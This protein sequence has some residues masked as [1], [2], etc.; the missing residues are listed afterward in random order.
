MQLKKLKSGIRSGTQITLN[1]SSN[2]NDESCDDAN[3]SHKLLL[4]KGQV[5]KFGKAF[6]NDSSANIN[7]LHTFTHLKVKNVLIP[8]GLPAAASEK[9]AAI[10]KKIHGLRTTTSVFS[11]EDLKDIIKI[12]K[13]L[14]ESGFLI[15]RVSET[16]KNEAKAQ[17]G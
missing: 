17:K 9:D 2:S 5:S 3:F 12:V 16:I 15:K 14:K 7:F 6:A 10:Q 13:S 4:T 11:N 8:L 1:F